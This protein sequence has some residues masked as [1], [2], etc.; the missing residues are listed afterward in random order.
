MDDIIHTIFCFNSVIRKINTL[1]KCVAQVHVHPLLNSV[2]MPRISL[3]Q[4]LN[5]T[6]FTL[7]KSE[8]LD[9]IEGL[10]MAMETTGL[11]AMKTTKTTKTTMSL[12]IH[13][14]T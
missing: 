4:E 7:I 11:T 12:S 1:G 9:E 5:Y 10:E 6:L 13:S 3:C 2:I 8:L 14:F